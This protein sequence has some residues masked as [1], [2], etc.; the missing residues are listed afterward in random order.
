MATEVGEHCE[1]CGKPNHKRKDCTS[2]HEPKHPD[3]NEEGKWVGC[4]TYKTI[5][6]WLASQW[7]LSR[8]NT[9]GAYAESKAGSTIRKTLQ[10]EPGRLIRLQETASERSGATCMRTLAQEEV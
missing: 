5:K 7:C 3:F 6:S 9:N 8:W 4:S 1:G 10:V 2:G